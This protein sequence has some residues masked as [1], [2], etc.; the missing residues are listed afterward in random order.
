V[1]ITGK[2]IEK[3]LEERLEELAPRP[4]IIRTTTRNGSSCSQLATAVGV[5]VIAI[6]LWKMTHYF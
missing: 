6:A 5:A 1:A 4:V 2:Q 3:L